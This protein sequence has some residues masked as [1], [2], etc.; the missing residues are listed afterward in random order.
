MEIGVELLV[1]RVGICLALVA[2]ACIHE[3]SSFPTSSS[4]GI[5]SPSHYSGRIVL[6]YILRGN[7]RF[8]KANRSGDDY[9][10]KA[11][12]FLTVPRGGGMP[13]PGSHLG[14]H[15]G[16]QEAKEAEKL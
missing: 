7:L 14:K 8:H 6:K 12:L 15:Q 4:N 1:H 11:G 5:V 2:S 10:C 13:V 9:L 3:S 16:G